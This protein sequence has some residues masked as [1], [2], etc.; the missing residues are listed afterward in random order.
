MISGCRECLKHFSKDYVWETS[1][2]VEVVETSEG[3]AGIARFSFSGPAI[4]L[5]AHN[6]PPL[7]WSLKKR[8]CAD[9]SFVTF[10]GDKARL[11]IVELKS[12][13]TQSEWA[14]ASE[15]IEGM[16]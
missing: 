14:K 15:Q 4:V 11:H 6:K 2:M 9:G 12:K 3:G 7:V 16:F 13:L 1:D 10:E 8:K 5:K